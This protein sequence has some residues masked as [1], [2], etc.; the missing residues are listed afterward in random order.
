[1]R[2]AH[3]RPTADRKVDPQ[4]HSVAGLVGLSFLYYLT[5]VDPQDTHEICPPIDPQNPS[6]LIGILRRK[7]D[8]DTDLPPEVPIWFRDRHANRQKSRFGDAIDVL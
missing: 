4:N 2:A 1:M 8:A 7:A 5:V 3:G 6:I